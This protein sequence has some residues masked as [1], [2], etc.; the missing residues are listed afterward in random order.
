MAEFVLVKI[1]ARFFQEGPEIA[2]E[3]QKQITNATGLATLVVPLEFQVLAGEMAKE[4]L[5]RIKTTVDRYL[6]A[7][8]DNPGGLGRGFKI[9]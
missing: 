3:I 7:T 6:A 9:G 8:G 2:T 5:I 1:P 4:E